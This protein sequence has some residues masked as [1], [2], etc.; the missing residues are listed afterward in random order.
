[1]VANLAVRIS[2]IS[3]GVVANLAVRSPLAQLH[4]S[5]AGPEAALGLLK[6]LRLLEL[7]RVIGG[8]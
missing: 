4:K 2:G 8:N 5:G 7:I 1:V 3:G 6:L